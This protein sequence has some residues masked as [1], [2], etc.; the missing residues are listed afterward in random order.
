MKN[1][2]LLGCELVFVASKIK[3][4]IYFTVKYFMYFN[5]S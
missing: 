5:V 1:A 2:Y 4:R 3:G